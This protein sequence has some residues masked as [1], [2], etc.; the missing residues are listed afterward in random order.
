MKNKDIIISDKYIN[1]IKLILIISS[2]ILTNS[3]QHG[4]LAI[5]RAISS[6]LVI[7]ITY[8]LLNKIKLNKLNK[9]NLI[10][11]LLISLYTSKYILGFAINNPSNLITVLSNKLHYNFV[12]EIL[13]VLFGLG[14][15]PILTL[16]I[17]LFI[18]NI[19]PKIKEFYINLTKLDKLYLA[20]ITII[21][22]IISGITICT[23]TA[24]TTP[25]TNDGA[26][27]AYDVIYT[28]DNGI[29]T[30][31]DAYLDIPHEENDIRQP[32][33]ALFASPFSI[34]A[35]AISELLPF[36]S[37][38]KNYYFVIIIFQFIITTIT[39]IM[40]AKLLKLKEED[41]KYFYILFSLSFPYLIFNLILEQYV[42]GLF[43]LILTI[44]L[45][46][47]SKSINYAYLGGVSTL[48]TTGILFPLITHKEKIKDKISEL[49]KA[50]MVFVSIFILCG[51]LQMVFTLKQR[52]QFL[53]SFTG[54][55]VLLVEKIQQFTNF[56]AGIF[57]A[58]IG[59]V[60]NN[61]FGYISYQLIVPTTINILGI[62]IFVICIISAF[63]NRKEYLAK[64]SLFWVLFS[65]FILLVM[66]WGTQ[67]NGLILYSLYFG[68]SY[69]TLIY[70]FIKKLFT[71]KKL[72]NIVFIII[73]LLMI[74]F[75]FK[76]LINIF[77]FAIIN[78]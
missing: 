9:I 26:Y 48:L 1:L 23:T 33:F 28:A 62:T 54:R 29:I 77:K 49:F 43:Y 40:L 19:L 38:S 56:I 39:T 8:I 42:I 73:I 70:L 34:T 13:H 57:I 53:M 4:L 7:I 37:D 16:Y 63:L 66:G 72:F 52:L 17:Y 14:I 32:L 12:F 5:Y 27:Q 69:I 55:E 58:P 24:F 11:S 75:N 15:I 36:S 65:V 31:K 67:E 47:E 3:F 51:R 41:K 45:Y 61:S 30:K 74:F 71:N 68:W 78:Y 6:I 46:K 25:Y 18:K 20:I 10:C 44:Y 60:I 59:E 64:I 21:G 50:F 76:E 35:H 2:V 22:I